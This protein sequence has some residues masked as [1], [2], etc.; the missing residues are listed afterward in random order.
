MLTKPAPSHNENKFTSNFGDG[1]KVRYLGEWCNNPN[2]LGYILVPA[3]SVIIY[4]QQI[5]YILIHV[6]YYIYI[7]INKMLTTSPKY[8]Y[9]TNIYIYLLARLYVFLI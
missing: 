9:I 3:G 6:H 1:I 8:K 2:E 4:I 7:Y 5:Q